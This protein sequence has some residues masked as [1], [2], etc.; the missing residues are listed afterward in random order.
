MVIA[1]GGA[2][3]VSEYTFPGTEEIGDAVT[4]ALGERNAALI[5]NHGLVGVGRSLTQALHVC[6]LTERIG[7]HLR[8]L[9]G[10]RHARAAA[11]GRR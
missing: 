4:A 5:R 9:Q 6:Q 8:G 1:I 11:I 7:S 3:Q 10:R 2:V